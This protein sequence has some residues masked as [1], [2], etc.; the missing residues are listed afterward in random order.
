LAGELVALKPDILVGISGSI[1]KPLFDASKGTIPVVGGMSEN[2]VRAQYATSLARPD[3]NFTGITFITDEM[4][5]KRIELLKEAAPA[6]K[7]V[8]VIWNPQHF[9]DEMTFA[10]RAA[11][12]LGIQLTSHPATSVTEVDAALR[13]STAS[14]ADSLFCIPSGLIALS[15]GRIAQYGRE[16]KLPVI[17]AWREFVDSGCLMSY[18]PSRA[19]EARRLA[20]YIEKILA[21]TKSADLPIEQPTR[22]ELVI[23]LK[24]ARQIGLDVPPLILSRADQVI[25]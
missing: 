20:G 10:K 25:E 24:T 6:T 7:H 23:N 16:Q 1:L 15:A 4:A 5:A 21:G 8:A 11:D 9:D 3:K 17:A 14:G 2:P 13:S 18:G 12:S 19:F 22:F